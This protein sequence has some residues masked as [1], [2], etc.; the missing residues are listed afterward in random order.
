MDHPAGVTT[1]WSPL[2]GIDAHDAERRPPHH[3]RD[4]SAHGSRREREP[5]ADARDGR[6]EIG[7]RVAGADAGLRRDVREAAR[8]DREPRRRI[9]LD[10]RPRL[11]GVGGAERR[12]RAGEELRE[13][14]V[15]RSRRITAG[16][17]DHR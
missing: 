6:A 14:A 17:R 11:P 8:G 3:E 12:R 9:R 7:D 13:R 2:S 5:R 1:R 16:R 10:E 15:E 4:G